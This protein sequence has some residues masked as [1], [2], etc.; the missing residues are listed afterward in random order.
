MNEDKEAEEGGVPQ[1]PEVAWTKLSVFFAGLITA[2]SPAASLPG[3]RPD[4]AAGTSKTDVGGA[5][6]GRLRER[7]ETGLLAAHDLAER[8]A[9]EA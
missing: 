4:C 9:S 6:A 2:A 8:G 7:R 3:R 5:L 1:A